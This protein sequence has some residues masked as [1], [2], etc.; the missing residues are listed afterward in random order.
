MFKVYSSIQY[1]IPLPEGHRF[2]IDKY[3]VL[4]GQLKYEGIL[5]ED[6]FATADFIP[7]EIIGLTHD[8][9]YWNKVKNLTL[10]DRA[11][12][13][14]GFPKEKYVIKR[15]WSSVSGTFEAT[16]QALELGLGINL[17]GG[18]HHA[19]FDRGEGFCVLNDVAIAANYLIQN[20]LSHKVLIVDLDVHQ[21][22]GTAS[23]FKGNENVF[24]FSMHCEQNYP[25]KKQESDLDIALNASTKGEE[26]LEKLKNTLPV[27][28]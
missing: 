9:T 10:D 23:I 13:K 21:G 24:T 19:F 28:I 26:Y 17:A 25:F 22:N 8:L 6:H 2:P 11:F 3:D 4:V 12:R 15:T 5:K 1:P 14:I 7:D 27:L 16:Q 20:Q 18:T